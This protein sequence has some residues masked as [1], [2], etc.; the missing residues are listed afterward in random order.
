MSTKRKASADPDDATFHNRD[1]HQQGQITSSG[2]HYH[3]PVNI[4]QGKEAVAEKRQSYLDSLSFTQ[5]GSREATIRTALTETCKWMLQREEFTL[6]LQPNVGDDGHKLLW[7]KGKPATGKSTLMKFLFQHVKKTR[8]DATVVSFFFNARGESL[9]KNVEGMY[10]SLLHQLLELIP[11]LADAFESLRPLSTSLS[12]GVWPLDRLQHLFKSAI[13]NLQQKTLIVFID[14][15]DEC[16]EDEVRE[17]IDFFDD[18]LCQVVSSANVDYHTCLSSRHYPH[19]EIRFGKS[20]VLESQGEHQEDIAKYIK[21]K[22]HIGTSKTSEWIKR[23]ILQKASGVFLWVVLV[24]K[25]LQKEFARGNKHK[26]QEQLKKIPPDLE[27]LLEDIL[28]REAGDYQDLVTCVQWILFSRRSLTLEELYWA[29]ISASCLSSDN[30]IEV[31]V[32]DMTRFVL[33]ASRGF[34]ESTRGKSPVMQFI[35][36]SVREY[37]ANT[38]KSSTY[39]FG[40]PETFIGRS[41]DHLKMCCQYFQTYHLSLL[42]AMAGD[43]AGGN[44][45]GVPEGLVT[46]HGFFAYAVK[47]IFFHS[48]AAEKYGQSQSEFLQLFD[49][50]TWTDLQNRLEKYSTRRYSR[51]VPL[52]YVLAEEHAPSLVAT[53]LEK[54]PHAWELVTKTKFGPRG[55][56][57]SAAVASRNVATISHLLRPFHRMISRRLSGSE[58]SSQVNW[59]LLD[60]AFATG[61]KQYAGFL[62]IIDSDDQDPASSALRDLVKRYPSGGMNLRDYSYA[63]SFVAFITSYPNVRIDLGQ[64]PPGG[65]FDSRLA[66]T[67][68]YLACS[69]TYWNVAAVILRQLNYSVDGVAPDDSLE[70]LAL[71]KQS[72]WITRPESFG[73]R[74]EH[75]RC[76]VLELFIQREDWIEQGPAGIRRLIDQSSEADDMMAMSMILANAVVHETMIGADLKLYRAIFLGHVTD[77]D[78]WSR[79]YLTTSQWYKALSVAVESNACEQIFMMLL[80]RGRFG[81]DNEVHR[82]DFHSVP[83]LTSTEAGALWD[84]HKRLLKVRGLRRL[85]RHFFPN[86]LLDAYYEEVTPLAVAVIV[87]KGLADS[88]KDRFGLSPVVQ[89]F[90]DSGDTGVVAAYL[91]KA[92]FLNET[93]ADY[94]LIQAQARAKGNE[95]VLQLLLEARSCTALSDEEAVKGAKQ[96]ACEYLAEIGRCNAPAVPQ[97]SMAQSSHFAR[98]NY[99]D[100]PPPT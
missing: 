97:T 41:H 35:H 40:P 42:P 73:E 76:A 56:V 31:T 58:E 46:S 9:E 34:V 88:P 33:N 78:E 50:A 20:I 54:A 64:V 4:Y 49:L 60:E 71:G 52:L 83:T 11:S 87:G 47:N 69:S 67:T 74:L 79:Q 26:L 57:L 66:S 21:K 43:N 84:S 6:W 99:Q 51:G 48:N 23:E 72:R 65:T 81:V 1:V 91:Q 44:P 77:A 90:R 36:E 100:Q 14:A 92:R 93:I 32:G 13:A 86:I 18:E 55:S 75:D 59:S 53:F 89:K 5:Q 25:I 8:K 27:E 12:G 98:Q 82:E 10:R 95:E 22:L 45:S 2:P 16:S 30:P 68:L 80:S 28:R 38:T 7:I 37:F 39:G 29:I 17:L 15:L 3:G 24:I 85:S 94:Y 19:V 70:R 63:E 62:K 61:S 96:A